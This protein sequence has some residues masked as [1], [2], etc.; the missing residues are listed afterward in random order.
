MDFDITQVPPRARREH[1]LYVDRTQAVE[2]PVVVKHRRHILIPAICWMFVFAVVYLLVTVF[3][4]PWGYNLYNTVKYGYP[5]TYQAD[6]VVGHSD[7]SAYPSHFIALNLRGHIEVIEFEGGNPGKA[8]VYTGPIVDDQLIPV[9]LSFS[10]QNGDGKLDMVVNVGG[11]PIVFYNN[12]KTFVL[13]H[14]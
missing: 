12:G 7:S 10:D 3:V 13:A 8:V 9:T 6:R 4:V 11:S 14:P 1:A 5:R 2:R